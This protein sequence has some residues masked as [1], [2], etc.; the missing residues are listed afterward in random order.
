MTK[1]LDNAPDQ[2]QG[3]S[4]QGHHL[5][6]LGQSPR[7]L[8][9]VNRVKELVKDR[10]VLLCMHPQLFMIKLMI[11]L[12][13]LDSRLPR[14][15]VDSMKQ[16]DTKW[17]ECHQPWILITTEHLKDG[18]GLDLI[19][20]M[21]REGTCL[22]A[23]LVLTANHR[24]NLARA[25]DAGTDAIVLEDSIEA[26]TGALIA[27]LTALRKNERYLD[28]A[29]EDTAVDDIETSLQSIEPLSARQQEILNLVAEGL[30]NKEIAERIHIAP[31]TARDHVQ[32]IMQKFGV[33]SRSAAAV[34]GIRLGLVSLNR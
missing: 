13:G 22:Q 33:Q 25:I 11:Q 31:S 26:Q 9:L 10:R 17:T 30:G 8:T 28:P 3:A 4:S 6:D 18:T 27:A 34:M 14:H 2:D 20:T 32:A 24:I 16:V 19:R 23:L 12:V 5:K 21:K 7:F 29:F 1:I 15:L